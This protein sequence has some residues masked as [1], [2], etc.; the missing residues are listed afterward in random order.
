MEQTGNIPTPPQTPESDVFEESKA[1]APIGPRNPITCMGCGRDYH[2]VECRG[3]RWDGSNWLPLVFEEM[4][5]PRPDSMDSSGRSSL[6]TDFPGHRDRNI[7][8]IQSIRDKIDREKTIISRLC[9][10]MAETNTEAIPSNLYSQLLDHEMRLVQFEENLRDARQRGISQ[11]V[12]G[13]SLDTRASPDGG[14][15]PSTL[16]P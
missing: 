7:D 8:L 13:I 14:R 9:A 11:D 12:E 2:G 16:C 1:P 6:I 10:M 3:W 15:G 4:E 5:S